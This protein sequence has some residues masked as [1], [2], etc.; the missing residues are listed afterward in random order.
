MPTDYSDFSPGIASQSSFSSSAFAESQ[1]PLPAGN[2]FHLHPHYR[3][4]LPLEATLLKTNTGLDKFITEQY[5]DQIAA[6]LAEWSAGLQKSSPDLQAI[7]KALASD[8]SGFSPQTAD[9]RLAR[10]GPTLEVR[11]IKFP[12]TTSLGRDAFIQ[13]LRSALNPFSSI[14][15][16]EFQ[17]VSIDAESMQNPMHLLTRVRYELVGSG[18]TF[19]REQRVGE[20]EMDWAL[21]RNPSD[22]PAK[23]GDSR[24][25]AWRALSET[26]SRSAEP[27]FTDIA[28]QVFAGAPSY[29]AQ[30]T[31]RR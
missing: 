24:L 18:H 12:L 23:A 28:T 17:I 10:S 7:E 5:A 25:R 13:Q 11:Q 19:H 4:Q 26:R 2:D 29:S 6:I 1:N 8:F 22:D 21:S 3:A 31:P 20:W 15:T 16:A 14:E 9:S 30:L 27:V